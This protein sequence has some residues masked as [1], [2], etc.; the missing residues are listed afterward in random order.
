MKDKTIKNILVNEL[1]V[2][3]D[4][5]Y[6]S[7]LEDALDEIRAAADEIDENEEC[8]EAALFVD[9][10]GDIRG[11]QFYLEDEGEFK[12]AVGQSAMTCRRVYSK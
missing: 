12:F 11:I 9:A 3:S 6:E 7:T 1:D 8:L 10:R 2:C 4:N 5:E